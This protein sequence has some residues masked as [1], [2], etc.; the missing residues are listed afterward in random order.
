MLLLLYTFSIVCNQ[1][2]IIGDL[3]SF[4]LNHLALP[5]VSTLLETSLFMTF[6]L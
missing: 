3:V 2:F 5:S 6:Y 4:S 1:T